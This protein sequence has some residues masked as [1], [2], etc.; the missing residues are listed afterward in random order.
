MIPVLNPEDALVKSKGMAPG[1]C[2]LAG[3][4]RTKSI[5]GYIYPSPT[6]L[7]G[8][9]QGKTLVLS[10]TN[11]TVALQ[12]SSSAKKVYISSLLNNPSVAEKIKNVYQTETIIIVCSRNSGEFSMEDF[13]GAGHLIDCLVQGKRD[14]FILNDATLAACTFYRKNV[15][16]AF[17]IIQSSH[18]GQ[19]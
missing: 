11:G 6:L 3:E 1:E 8:M 12:I 16:E 18:V 2:L 19:P 15:D 13:Y 4:L 9:V 17:Q 10:I 7:N 5:E 14:A